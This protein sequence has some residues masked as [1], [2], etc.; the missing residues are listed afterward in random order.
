MKVISRLLNVLPQRNS[1]QI[2]P[3]KFF[4]CERPKHSPRVKLP[5]GYSHPAV[6]SR[7][8]NRPIS[9]LP[10]PKPAAKKLKQEDVQLMYFME[11]DTI[12]SINEFY[13]EKRTSEKYN[14]VVTSRQKY[15]IVNIFMT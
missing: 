2:N 9:C 15:K 11:K 14:N 5:G 8:F 10:T 4:I 1:F 6:P 12:R 13:P 3:A 7:V